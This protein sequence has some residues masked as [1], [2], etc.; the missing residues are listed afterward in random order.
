MEFRIYNRPRC[1][2]FDLIGYKERDQTKGLGFLLANSK[3]AMEALLD[4]IFPKT[5]VRSYLKLDWEVDCEFGLGSTNKSKKIDILVRFFNKSV[6]EKSIIIE[7]KSMRGTINNKAAFSQIS[8]YKSLYRSSYKLKSTDI[9]LVTLT[10]YVSIQKCSIQSLSWQDLMNRF[11]ACMDSLKKTTKNHRDLLLIQDYLNYI[12]KIQGIM[13]YYD[14]EVLVIPATKTIKALKDPQ[15]GIY[16]CPVGTGQFNNRA[17]G[18]PLYIAFKDRGETN[19]LYKL[20][21]V[22]QIDI[23]DQTAIDSLDN[24]IENGVRRYPDF[25]NKINRYKKLYNTSVS[26]QKWIFIIDYENSIDLYYPV[27]IPSGARGHEYRSLKDVFNSPAVEDN[28]R[29]VLKLPLKNGN[30]TKK[31]RSAKNNTLNTSQV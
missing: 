16:E 3:I 29:I 13:N 2:L 1:N 27:L 28:G 19:T 14:N 24:I 6:L 11:Y 7:A 4:L 22:V 17:L 8:A 15:C 10:T 30:S 5:T 31:S 25:K 21:D 23:A 9:T 12:N 20:K 18:H 26:G